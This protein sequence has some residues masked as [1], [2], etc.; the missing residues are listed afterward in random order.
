MKDTRNLRNS[1]Y[2]KQENY[3][4]NHAYIHRDKTTESQKQ[5]E[6]LKSTQRKKTHYLQKSNKRP[7]ADFS[8]FSTETLETRSK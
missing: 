6:N 1:L 4:E 5:R 2:P 3:E 8:E 7:T